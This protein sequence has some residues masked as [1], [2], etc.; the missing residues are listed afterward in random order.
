MALVAL[1]AVA[2]FGAFASPAG[3]ASKRAKVN[4]KL[5]G[6]SQAKLIESGR[7]KVSA[8]AK[9]AAK[10]KLVVIAHQG[11]KDKRITKKVKVKLKPGKK[12]AKKLKLNDRG[13]RWVQS[14]IG[15]KLEGRANSKGDKA[16]AAKKKMKRDP[17]ICDGST[18]VGVAVDT[19][20]RC[21]AIT[22][23][24]TDC[25]F[26]YPNDHFTRAGLGDR[27]GPAPEPP[28]GL[29]AGQ[30]QG[31]DLRPDRDQHQR[32]VQPGRADRH[33]RPGPR[34][35]GG[36]RGERASC[37]SRRWARPTTTSSRSC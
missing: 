21:E 22:P 32:R 26:P 25:L 29:D 36:L 5:G 35:A 19:A 16:G 30:Q 6:T 15:T 27:H 37:R 23:V 13:R 2:A 11:E 34:H 4:V 3:A 31:H 24:G 8:R 1:L 28:A 18:P 20:D 7:V 12:A 14:C 17:T 10:G 33:P 9:D